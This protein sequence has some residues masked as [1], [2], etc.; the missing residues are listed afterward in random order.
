MAKA[1]EAPRRER[2][3]RTR[4]LHSAIELA[5]QT[6]FDGLSMRKLAE[7]LGVVPMAL[8]KHVADKD[9]LL[10]GMVDLVFAEVDV[11][12]DVDWKTAM[13]VMG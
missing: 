13:R 8:Y 10:D 6:G 3:N 1:S 4:V 11:P 5:D 7:Q 12:T 2:L 9:E